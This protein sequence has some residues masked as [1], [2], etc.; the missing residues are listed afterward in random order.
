MGEGAWET[1]SDR[2]QKPCYLSRVDHDDK[3]RSRKQRRDV[4]KYSLLNRNIQ[5]WNQ[6]PADVLG[7]LSCESS[8]FR[9][10]LGK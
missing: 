7:T 5:L 6:L 10:K 2:L 3:I 9:E 4:R 8:T 1:I